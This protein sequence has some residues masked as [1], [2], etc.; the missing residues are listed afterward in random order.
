MPGGPS[1][2]PGFFLA[3]RPEPARA[4]FSFEITSPQ[5]AHADAFLRAPACAVTRGNG[6]A[7]RLRLAA[8]CPGPRHPSS[9]L[10]CCSLC[11]SS[12]EPRCAR[13]T[14]LPALA[15]SRGAS[16]PAAPS[17]P[18]GSARTNVALRDPFEA[19][20]WPERTARLRYRFP[21]DH[22]DVGRKVVAAGKERRADAVGVDRHPCRLEPA[23]LRRI[24]SA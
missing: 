1:V 16:P 17:W 2:P 15:K 19:R 6:S 11:S 18:A 5:S 20:V 23:N 14:S 8:P 12:P 10:D 21:V 22:H 4:R 13:P 3:L 24:E 9:R 7:L